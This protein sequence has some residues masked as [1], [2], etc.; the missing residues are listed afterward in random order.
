MVTPYPP[1][2][3]GVASYAVQE[4]GQ[5]LAEG[6]EVEVLSPGPSA[7]HHHLTLRG[8]RGPL[9]LAR[10]M[11]GYDK[12][13]VQFHP[14]LFFPEPVGARER[15]AIS[16]GLALAWSLTDVDVRV[17]EIDYRWGEEPTVSGR[18]FRSLWRVPRRITVH[19][20]KER[21]RFAAAM[22]LDP[23]RVEVVDHGAHFV[24]RTS[25][26]R[27]AARAALAIAPD[28]RV[29]LAIGFI[30]SHKG[31]DRAVQAFAG[32][33]EHSSR[34][35]IVGSVRVDEP[36][37]IDYRDELRAMVDATPGVHL[38]EGYVSDEAFDRWLVASDV[39]VLPYRS[40]WSSSVL[41]RAALFD[42][43]VIATRVGGL[44]SQATANTTL[45]RSDAELAAAM[46]SAAGAVDR[47]PLAE[48]ESWPVTAGAPVDRELVQAEVRRRAA[49]RRPPRKAVSVARR[50]RPDRP[51]LSTLRPLKLPPSTSSGLVAPA[52]KRAVRRLVAWQVDPIVTHVNALQ[53]AAVDASQE[54]SDAG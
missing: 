18:V 24:A 4:V 6:H 7:A 38:H 20:E 32:L 41:E 30:Q 50:H 19:T 54:P 23:S 33:D 52:I 34:L 17:H 47:S 43:H 12:V 31:F 35:D 53:R 10:R 36:E 2:R 27:E 45:V 22:Q 11:R 37:F 13:I 14:D 42:K 3:D 51:T 1:A 44:D 40:I 49:R 16:M 15:D 39:V 29:F 48:D 28:E 26:D 9:A 25:L 21:D 46:W 8:V 5:L